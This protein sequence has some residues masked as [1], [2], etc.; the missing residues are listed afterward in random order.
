MVVSL[1]TASV[2]A[3]LSH[4]RLWQL[5]DRHNP[6][7]ALQIEEAPGWLTRYKLQRLSGDRAAC[8]AALST[9]A[10]RVTSVP[11]R[12]PSPGCGFSNAVRIERTAVQIG[13]PF[14]L[15]CPAA[16]SMALWERH[17]LMPAAQAELGSPVRR[18]D[19]FGSYA[20][21]NVYGRE[22]GRRSQHAT[23]DA[24]D[25]AGFTLADGRRITVA[26]HWRGNDDRARFLHSV[27]DQAC[28]YFDAVF[29]PDY[30]AAHAD[31]FHLDRG[32]FRVCR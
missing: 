3:A 18:I 2:G 15:S 4:G 22:G 9:S 7:A 31:H 20:C 6:W 25:V 19:H 27:H 28:P 11:D 8:L 1:F 29:G 12:Q 26:A 14:T 13:E 16:V 23:A 21:R 17:A 24:L 5:P 10:L 32:P 30:N